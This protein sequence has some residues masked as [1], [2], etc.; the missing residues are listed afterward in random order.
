MCVVVGV[1]VGMGVEL[2]VRLVVGGVAGVRVE[3]GVAMTDE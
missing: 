1:R 3:G 2:G